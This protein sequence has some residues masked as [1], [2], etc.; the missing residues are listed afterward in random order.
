MPRRLPRS[1]TLTIRTINSQTSAASPR[2]EATSSDPC[3]RAL[4]TGH[5]FLAKPG[6]GHPAHRTH[7]FLGVAL[8]APGPGA[9]VGAILPM[10]F[11]AS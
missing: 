4:L 7:Y 6:E 5:G 2:H 8:G 1:H 10:L 9:P 11:M 3:A